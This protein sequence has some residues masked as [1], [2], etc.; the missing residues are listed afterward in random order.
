MSSF[1]KKGG[2]RR[3]NEHQAKG[4]TPRGTT[5]G[6]RN[7]MAK[8]CSAPYMGWGGGVGGG[9]KKFFFSKM[10]QNHPKSLSK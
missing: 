2:G 5:P 3:R 9:V 6:S 4:T 10:P 1:R 8:T 7:K